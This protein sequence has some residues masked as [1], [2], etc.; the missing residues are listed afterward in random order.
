MK[1]FF[2]LFGFL[3]FISLIFSENYGTALIIA[4]IHIIDLEQKLGKARKMFDAIEDNI[5]ISNIDKE[6]FWNSVKDD[7]SL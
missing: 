5:A 6:D 1:N 7:I 4:I 2:Y 3:I